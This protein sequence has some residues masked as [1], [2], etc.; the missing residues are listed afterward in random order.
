[1]KNHFLIQLLLLLVLIGGISCKNGSS[2]VSEGV[3]K[4]ILH[5]GNQTEP[6]DLDPHIVTGVPEF[7]ILQSLFEGLVT[8]DPQDL[9]PLPGAA[10]SWDI[11]ADQ[12][13]YTFHLRS[14][15]TWSNGEMVK[16]GDFVFSFQRILSPGL[17]SEY[18]YM[19]YCINNAEKFNKGVITDFTQVGAKAADDTTLVIQLGT[20]TPYFMSLIMH[21]S[22]YPVHPAT[23]LK[24]GKIDSRGSRWTRPENFVGNGPFKL[25]SWE[26]N[27]LISVG[28]RQD[29]WD[30]ADIKLNGIN[31]YPVENIQT[32]E[33]MFRNDQ[34]HVTT[35]LPS[36]KIDWYKQ[37]QSE[38][39]RI[40]PYLGTYYYICNISRPP[41]DNKKLRKAL[42]LSIDRQSLTR[43]ILKGGQIPAGS[44]TPPNTAGYAFGPM[45]SFDTTEARKL[46]AE[47][48]IKAGDS[49]PP[50]TILYNTS[51]SHHIIAQAIQQMW[52]RYLGINV[53]LVNQEWKVYLSSKTRKEYD[54]ARMGWIGDY[55]DPNSF[56]DLW[57]TGGG[58]NN[59]GWSNKKYDSLIS[60]ASKAADVAQRFSL[61]NQAESLFLDELPAIPIYF[62]TNVYLLK[63]CVKGWYQNILNMHNFKFI[64]LE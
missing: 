58:N 55:N 33:R 24:F 48:G 61:F 23:I 2:V 47:S 22:W 5:F 37:N 3:E 41:L 26:I 28:K 46:L 29:Y 43:D 6:E 40:D 31:F 56:L 13:T 32:E 51:E 50:I 8:P 10:R 49:L 4:G 53:T 19:L 14:E 38:V 35:N 45:I 36:Q 25:V 21:D 20:P 7:H 34:L 9:H 57:L 52:K 60:E 30:A 11:S 15:G 44:F 27:K 54:I 12:L 1:M 18:A 59:T 17:G 39:L 62:Y 63:P 64:S 16:A 42:A